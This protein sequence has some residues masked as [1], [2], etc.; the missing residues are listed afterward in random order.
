MQDESP[1]EDE[2]SQTE[3][4]DPVAADDN[5]SLS[6][7]IQ[8]LDDEYRQLKDTEQLLQNALTKLQT[9]EHALQEGIQECTSTSAQPATRTTPQDAEAI[10][11]LQEALM[12]QSSSED[13]ASNDDQSD[14]QQL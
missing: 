11:R 13:D 6:A 1:Q 14:V 7:S 2:P 12:M 10:R 8:Q 9:D 3:D 4:D 5:G